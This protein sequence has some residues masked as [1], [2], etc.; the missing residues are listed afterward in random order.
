MNMYGRGENTRLRDVAVAFGD[1]FSKL[2]KYLIWFIFSRS[3]RIRVW[4]HRR[5]VKQ[6]CADEFH[7]S[8]NMDG[9]ALMYMNKEEQEKYYFDLAKRRNA[10]HETDIVGM[11]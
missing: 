11:K 3:S 1:A 10:A 7:Y 9:D 6:A 4:R 2:R 5:M 8:L